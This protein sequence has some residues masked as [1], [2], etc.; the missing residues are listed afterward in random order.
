MTEKELIAKIKELRQIKPKKDWVVLAKAQI[1]GEEKLPVE[2]KP[3][4]FSV[5]PLNEV[6]AGLRVI[7]THK[8]AFATLTLILV[9]VGVFGFA[10]NTLPGDLLFPIKK[11]SE[12]GRTFFV[13]NQ[14]KPTIQL[15]LTNK[16]LEELKKIAKANQ[17]QKLAPALKEFQASINQAAEN[18]KNIKEP[19]KITKEIVFQTKKLEESKAEVEALGV[20]IGETGELEDALSQLVTREI[21]DLETRTLT[22]EQSRILE[23][24]K[25]DYE[26]KN[27]SKALEKILTL[28]PQ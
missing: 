26:A 25:K 23:E 8:F 4:H 21:K 28:T 22:E 24:V 11:I 5:F 15:E 27:Y 10:Q 17:T 3:Q 6:I 2:V 16:R 12:Q 9:L 13:S 20:V 14:E 19:Q 7:F 18:I 1:L